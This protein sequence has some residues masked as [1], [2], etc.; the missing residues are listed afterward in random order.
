MPGI[1]MAK[2]M[3]ICASAAQDERV[4]FDT[5][6]VGNVLLERMQHLSLAAD[7][8]PLAAPDLAQVCIHLFY[9][10]SPELQVIWKLPNCCHL[11]VHPMHS[12]V[13]NMDAH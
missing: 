5:H 3:T 12:I 10:C 4:E 11:D 7:S 8:D 13:P 1:A 9:R 2:L 6:A